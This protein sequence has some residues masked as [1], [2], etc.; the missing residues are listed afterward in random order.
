[1]AANVNAA[2]RLSMFEVPDGRAA[3]EVVQLLAEMA[4]NGLSAAR[5]YGWTLT[6]EVLAP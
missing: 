5:R 1:M 4:Q 2:V 3:Y 6:I